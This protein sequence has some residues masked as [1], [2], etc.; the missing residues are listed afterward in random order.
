MKLK[1]ITSFLTAAAL[2]LSSAYSTKVSALRSGFD[3]TA[4][5]KQ[6][7]IEENVLTGHTCGAI[8]NQ[9]VYCSKNADTDKILMTL[10][11]ENSFDCEWDCTDYSTFES[12]KLYGHSGRQGE[13]LEQYDDI[14]GDYSIKMC[15]EN[16][17]DSFGY[18]VFPNQ[19]VMI[20]I[21]EG[22]SGD[23][24]ST[25]TD[26]YNTEK[27]ESFSVSENQIY[28]VYLVKAMDVNIYF[29]VNRDNKF[30]RDE[31]SENSVNISQIL[32]N[33]EIN[34][35]EIR[36]IYCAFFY[37]EAKNDKGHAEILKNSFTENNKKNMYG[38]EP[39]IRETFSDNNNNNMY[40]DEPEIH[41]TFHDID[42][43]YEKNFYCRKTYNKYD[44]EYFFYSNQKD[45]SMTY[46]KNHS[47]EFKWNTENFCV[48]SGGPK[49]SR[50]V[51]FEKYNELSVD[52]DAEYKP[53]SGSSLY[54]IECMLNNM[55]NKTRC[56]VKIVKDMNGFVPDKDYYGESFTVNDTEYKIY[57]ETYFYDNDNYNDIDCIRSFILVPSDL[58]NS[59]EDKDENASD[60]KISGKT[61]IIDILKAFKEVLNK[62]NESDNDIIL[63]VESLRLFAE[64]GNQNI[65]NSG[66]E[67]SIT[68]N[69]NDIVMDRTGSF[70]KN[71]DN[72]I[73]IQDFILLKNEIKEKTESAEPD[74]PEYYEN[75]FEGIMDIKDMQNLLFGM[76]I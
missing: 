45:T 9:T 65:S 5:Y 75:V 25:L 37:M 38:Y 14:V 7:D 40:G 42:W 76:E 16:G 70:D 27:I 48:A 46:K 64:G 56:S 54:G 58:L 35:L 67:G 13:S 66:S 10:N 36:E 33:M 30:C 68:V 1:K 74:T 34:S 31:I 43:A 19:F 55:E 32:R 29:C 59:D 21:V 3:L 39:I 23:Y 57:Q 24:I 50:E 4:F 63:K 44:Y 15:P 18:I 17:T 51:D 28:D 61:N 73:N 53:C 72:N 20:Y 11:D 69:R 6:L 62:H 26:E 8:G 47:F 52:F 49:A 71:T 41:E 60:R 22:Y 12:G 2:L